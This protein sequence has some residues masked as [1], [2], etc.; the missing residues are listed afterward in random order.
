MHTTTVPAKGRHHLSPAT[1]RYVDELVRKAPPLSP[2]TRHRVEQ[3][4]WGRSI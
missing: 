1:E 2:E 3:L 4:L